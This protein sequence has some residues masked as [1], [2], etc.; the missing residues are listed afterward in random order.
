MLQQNTIQKLKVQE[1]SVDSKNRI[2]EY[3]SIEKDFDSINSSLKYFKEHNQAFLDFFDRIV[4]YM[5]T[6]EYSISKSIDKKY[7]EFSPKLESMST[8]FL[9]YSLAIDDFKECL[10]ALDFDNQKESTMFIALFKLSKVLS[11][12]KRFSNKEHSDKTIPPIK[13]NI[14]HLVQ[15]KIPSKNNIITIDSLSKMTDNIEYFSSVI[16]QLSSEKVTLVDKLKK[17]ESARLEHET[18][19]TLCLLISIKDIP[20]DFYENLSNEE[21]MLLHIFTAPQ[22]NKTTYTSEDGLLIRLSDKLLPLDQEANAANIKILFELFKQ[23][24][25]YLTVDENA[26]EEI[27]SRLDKIQQIDDPVIKSKLFKQ[28]NKSKSAVYKEY[29][30]NWD[31]INSWNTPT[32]K[33]ET[34]SKSID[35]STT[36]DIASTQEQSVSLKQKLTLASTPFISGAYS[37]KDSFSFIQS[38]MIGVKQTEFIISL[39]EFIKNNSGIEGLDKLITYAINSGELGLKKPSQRV[40]KMIIGEKVLKEAIKININNDDRVIVYRDQE[41]SQPKVIFMTGEE[42]HNQRKL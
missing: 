22:I 42:Y 6:I 18:S 23:L 16:V 8:D 26:E 33:N 34:L 27:K 38:K 30:E 1:S 15:L 17:L 32:T 10:E 24:D 12:W 2:Y 3:Q 37:A 29:N 14:E 28:F 9:A 25:K 20:A 39:M 4:N 35:I 7:N 5:D 11:Y 40:P 31:K 36:Q 21:T 19:D 13:I 41:N